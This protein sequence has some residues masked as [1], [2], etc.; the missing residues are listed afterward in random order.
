[1]GVANARGTGRPRGGEPPPVQSLRL[2]LEAR[3]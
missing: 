3:G 2:D 1:V